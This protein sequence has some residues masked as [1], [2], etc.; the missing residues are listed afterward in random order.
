DEEERTSG[1]SC[2][3][4]G[5][6][7]RHRR[8]S[9]S[10]LKG[11]LFAI[12]VQAYFEI[13]HKI[14]RLAFGDY[15]LGVVNPLDGYSLPFL[16]PSSAVV[17]TVYIDVSG[18]N[19]QSNQFS[20]TEHFRNAGHFQTVPGVFFFYDLSPI[21]ASKQREA[22]LEAALAKKEFAEEECRKKVDEAKKKEASLENDLANM[23]VL[24]ARL[25]KDDGAIPDS[26]SR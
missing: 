24:V 26:K 11:I 6:R 21:K 19:I 15:I 18:H 25:K 13:T 16:L 5:T 1:L 17:S 14:N 10:S 4:N 20:V 2:A 8:T 3:C 9:P 7:L 22:A 12:L 23:W